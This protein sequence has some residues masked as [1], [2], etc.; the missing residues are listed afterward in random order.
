VVV[1]DIDEAGARAVAEW[2]AG[3]GGEAIAERVDLADEKSI[4]N[5]F[6]RVADRCGRLDILH[7]NAADTRMEQIVR[8]MAIDQMDAEV[9]DRAFHVNVRGTMLMIKHAIP[10]LLATGKG[11]IINTSS[12]ASLRGDFY[13]PAYAS[14]KAAINCLTQYV[15]TQYGKKGIR[16]NAV[17]P[18]L[19]L[20]GTA[21]AN[22]TDEQLQRIESHS[23]TSSLGTPD[24]IAAAVA[25]LASDDARLVTGQ[26]LVVDG[27]YIS[28][29]PHV[30]EN[31]ENFNASPGGRTV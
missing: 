5:L 4:Q 29:M 7:N 15:A 19:I 16:C 1:A 17:S 13:A 28:H 18:G 6:A 9:W 23:L 30:A 3:Q 14:S 8:D 31:T 20:T 10:Q 26:V 22:N 11:A 12:G 2:I 25:Y 21:R 24:D 27:G